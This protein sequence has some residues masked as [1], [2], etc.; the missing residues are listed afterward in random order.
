[1]GAGAGGGHDGSAASVGAGAGQAMGLCSLTAGLRMA[2]MC[3]WLVLHPGRWPHGVPRGAG[4]QGTHHTNEQVGGVTGRRACVS[5][6]GSACAL[7]DVSM[8]LV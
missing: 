2:V 1:M 7:C 4:G 3:G 6:S 5:A 8:F